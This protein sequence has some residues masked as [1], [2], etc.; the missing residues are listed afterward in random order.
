VQTKDYLPELQQPPSIINT[1]APWKRATIHVDTDLQRIIQKTD[2]KDLKKELTL[3]YLQKYKDY[4]HV[5]T[6]ASKASMPNTNTGSSYCIPDFAVEKTF[7]LQDN[8]T[9]HTAE[10]LA[11]KAALQYTASADIEYTGIV[12]L[13]DSITSVNSINLN[14]QLFQSL[15]TEISDIISE[16]ESKRQI[17]TKLVWIPSH[18][19]VEGNEK[20]DT[21]AKSALTK[22]IVDFSINTTKI[23]INDKID[24][25]MLNE[26][27]KLYEKSPT[28]CAYKELEPKVSLQTKY[29]NR[30]RRKE[31]EITRLRLGKCCLNQY[32]YRINK[33]P[34][35]YCDFCKVP[36]T[37]THFLLQCPHSAVFSKDSEIKTVT[38]ALRTEANIDKIYRILRKLNKKI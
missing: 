9:I 35:G 31:I 24:R 4:L 21:L 38:E 14:S 34:T 10:L 12:I 1:L 22:K 23:E 26:W 27:Q 18:V 28:G 8:V 13:T 32:L 16:K 17:S 3:D 7:R 6:D 11:I 19:G 33:H 2:S 5:Y 36:E 20:A 15:E 37:I 30:N 29:T 25:L